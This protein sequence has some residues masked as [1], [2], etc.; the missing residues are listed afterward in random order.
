MSIPADDAWKPWR[1]NEAADR[2]A[3]VSAPWCVVGGWALDL[4]HGHQTRHHD[5]LEIAILRPQLSVFRAHLKEFTCCVAGSGKVD[6]LQSDAEPP[7][8]KHQVW[9]LD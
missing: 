7:P 4:W 8:E 1:P 3:G 2:L 9:I 6:P 5:D